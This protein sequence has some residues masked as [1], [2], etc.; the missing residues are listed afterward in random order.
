MVTSPRETTPAAAGLSQRPVLWWLG[1]VTSVGLGGFISL[2]AALLVGLY[3][4]SDEGSCSGLPPGEAWGVNVVL[5]AVLVVMAV[6]WV[7]MAATSDAPRWRFGLGG[8]LAVS[9]LLCALWIGIFLGGFSV[10]FCI[11]F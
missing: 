5:S 11:P 1:W 2:V 3:V 8:L 9:P 10:D 7:V 6:P 4:P